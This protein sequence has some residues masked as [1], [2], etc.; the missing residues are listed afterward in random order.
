MSLLRRHRILEDDVR[1]VIAHLK[2]H[3]TI[4]KNDVLHRPRL[5]KKKKGEGPNEEIPWA[6]GTL[7]GSWQQ[8]K[9]KPGPSN[10]DVLYTKENDVWKLV[11]PEKQITEYL[12][13]AMLDTDSKMPFGRDSAYHHV[14]RLTVGISRR[15]LYKFLE[16]QGVLQITKNI[17]NEQV[18][19]GIE[20][21]KRG[22]CEM[23]LIEG[24]GIDLKE[25][26]GVKGNWY[27]LAVVDVLTGYG[28]VATIRKKKAAVVAKVLVQVL[29]LMDY[30]L[31][32]KV[33]TMSA[34]H[35][36]EFFAEVLVML[37][38]RRITMKQVA[39]GSRVEKFNQDFQRN[40]Y[41]LLRMRRGKFDSLQQ[42]ALDVTNNTKNKNTKKTP[43]EALKIPDAIL[44]KGYNDGRQKSKPYKCKQLK[45]GDKC[46]HLVKLRKNIY[47]ILKIGAQARLYKTYHGRHFTKQLFRITAIKPRPPPPGTKGPQPRYYVNGRWRQRDELLAVTGTDAATS[48]AIAARPKKGPGS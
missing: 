11:V 47:P 8:A 30:K 36:R 31:G 18:K 21:Y 15:A 23:D 17:P 38:K 2:A 44:E 14:Q 41:R 12:R 10:A 25:N 40:F 9:L 6:H 48:A 7:A 27:W 28:L 34:D 5:K 24:K 33:H 32:T 35:G 3:K 45:V 26:L 42:Q 37:K 16:K 13:K 39:R 22:Y 43:E 4:T 20:L 29:D 46:R 19:G 1:R